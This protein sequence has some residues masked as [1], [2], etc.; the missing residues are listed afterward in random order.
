MLR[1]HNEIIPPYLLEGFEEFS[2]AI[3][4]LQRTAAATNICLEKLKR[5]ASVGALLPAEKQIERRKI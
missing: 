5:S 3:H 4:S 2:T 1:E